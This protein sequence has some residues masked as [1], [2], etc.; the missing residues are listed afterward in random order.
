MEEGNDTLQKRTD[1]EMLAENK[2]TRSE[3]G[4]TTLLYR[5]IRLNTD[6]ALFSLSMSMACLFGYAMKN[7]SFCWGDLLTLISSL[8]TGYFSSSFY[9]HSQPGSLR[10]RLISRG[11][12][13]QSQLD[14]FGRSLVPGSKLQQEKEE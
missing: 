10:T 3:I 2:K 13:K 12:K 7:F 8:V 14:C 11:N 1:S 6:L 9:F 4:K 5:K